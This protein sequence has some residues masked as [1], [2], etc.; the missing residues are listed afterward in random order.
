LSS[1]GE[2]K[3][4]SNDTVSVGTLHRDRFGFKKLVIFATRTGKV[5]AL[6]TLKGQV[7][8]ERYFPGLSFKEIDM[9]RSAV[10]KFPPV[11]SLVGYEG[12]V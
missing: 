1:A 5:V 12:K 3:P 6:E 2:A 9:V 7:V 10:V 4:E 8:W 11:L